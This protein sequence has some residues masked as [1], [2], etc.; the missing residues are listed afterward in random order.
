MHR[1]VAHKHALTTSPNT[2]PLR[3]PPSHKLSQILPRR[4]TQYEPP[5]RIRHHRKILLPVRRLALKES[6]QLLQR[7]LHRDE[8]VLAAP[9]AEAHHGFLYTVILRDVASAQLAL[10]RG[11]GDV[12]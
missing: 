1:H 12:A 8:R 11:R 6:L 4:N 10:N 5:S 7:R 9:A 2:S 3:R